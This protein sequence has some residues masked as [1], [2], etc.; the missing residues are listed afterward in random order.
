[1]GP[2]PVHFFYRRTASITDPDVC[3]RS[4]YAALLE[5]H[6]ITESEESREQASPEEMFHKLTNLLSESIAPRLSPSRGLSLGQ[7]LRQ[8]TRGRLWPEGTRLESRT[9]IHRPL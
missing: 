8:G 5:A 9:L 7:H 2:P 3:V 1:M 4:L 6:N